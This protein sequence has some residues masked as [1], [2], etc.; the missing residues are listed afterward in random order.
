MVPWTHNLINAFPDHPP[1]KPTAETGDAGESHEQLAAV[2]AR[3]ERATTPTKPF[4]FF[5]LPSELR[6]RI[7]SLLIFTNP[8]YRQHDPARPGPSTPYFLISRRFHAEASYLLYTNTIFRIFPLQDFNP[9]PTVRELPPQYR[10][11]VATIELVLGPSWTAPPQSW[12]V[13]KSMARVLSG[14]DAVQTLRVF[15]EIDPSHPVFAK[16]RVSHGFYTEFSGNLLKAILDAMPRLEIVQI[17]GRPSVQIDGPLVS[18]LK[19]EIESQGRIVKLGEIGQT[20]SGRTGDELVGGGKRR[21][22]M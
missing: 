3:S 2:A 12:T 11:L 9:L 6:N 1:P 17:D 13:N 4:P 21:L 22:T 8:P 14:M 15:V 18:R 7:Y 19:R 20:D 5:R 10:N 16:F